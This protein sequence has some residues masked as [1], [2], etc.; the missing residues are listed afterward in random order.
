MI[1]TNFSNDNALPLPSQQYEDYVRWQSEMLATSEGERLAAYWEK[2]LMGE[3]PFLNNPL[4]DRPNPTVQTYRGDVYLDRLQELTIFKLKK[5]EK[6]EKTSIFQI[7]LAAFYVLL[8]RLSGQEEIPLGVPMTTGWPGLKECE[9]VVGML[10]NPVVCR[11]NLAGN[12]TFKELLVRVSSTL[13]EV[14][15]YRDYPFSLLVSR[16]KP[17]RNNSNSPI[18]QV[19]FGWETQ[20][21]YEKNNLLFERGDRALKIEPYLLG[22]QGGGAFDLYL[23][24]LE[25]GDNLQLC[26]KYST[27]LFN[28]STITCIASYFQT[29][30]AGIITSPNQ[31]IAKLPLLTAA[32]QH[33]LLVKWNNTQTDCCQERCIHQWFEELIERSPNAVAVV[34]EGKQLT[35]LELNQQANQ[36]ARYLQTLGIEPEVLVGICVERSLEMI[37]GILGVLKAGAAYVPLDP[38]YPQERLAYMV[39]DSQL[40]VLLTQQRLVEGLPTST[41]KVVCLDSDWETITSFSKENPVHKVTPDN[42][43]YAVYTSGSTGKPKGVLIAHRGLCNLVEAQ[44]RSFSVQPNSCVLQF[45]SFSFDASV[46]EIFMALGAGAKLAIAH[47]ESLQ[48]GPDLIK[49]FQKQKIT[50]VTL[51]PSILAALPYQ[52]LPTLQTMIVAGENCPPNLAKKWSKGRRFFN[53]YGP[54]E[55]TVC[56][57]IAEITDIDDKLP[58][59]RPIANTQVYI[60]DRHLQPVPIGVPGE[61]QIGGIGLARGYLNRPDLTAE[62]FISNPFSQEKGARLYKTGDL[63]RYLPD[64]NIE[65]LERID[66]LVKIRGFRIELREIESILIQ[67][68]SVQQAAVIDR[69]DIPGNKRLVAYL[70]AQDN[71]KLGE[72]RNFLKTKLPDYMLPSAF[73]CLAAM[74]VTSSGKLDLRSLPTPADLRPE[75]ETVYVNPETEIETMIAT[76]WQEVLGLKKVGVNDNFFELGGHSLLIPQIHSK[77]LEVVGQQVSIVELFQ[78]PTIQSLSNHLSQK[79]NIQPESPSIHKRAS[80][81]CA[82]IAENE[83]QRQRRRKHRDR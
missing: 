41:A 10:A 47:P 62:K 81:R 36:L 83:Q 33:Q 37:V 80:T 40:P 28:A 1:K 66:R 5:L 43:A 82:L 12:P 46:S 25:A 56:A 58:I 3:L 69:E 50:H 59:G 77:L 23:T 2:Q 64:G 54:S 9:R 6:I 51:P 16:L 35:Y 42:L 32:E 70:V 48:P 74:P 44:I 60:L 4:V 20:T 57:T 71:L 30:L 52:E 14:K 38:N 22:E 78:Y 18:L 31:H 61:L 65:F 34:F 7:C 8:E 15:E 49:L 21:W 55:T 17:H 39:A 67:Y 72:L 68:P 63:A 26:W 24:I 73:V 11:V 75:L 13:N 29:L 19:C 53:A 76:V 27:D 79:K 45:A